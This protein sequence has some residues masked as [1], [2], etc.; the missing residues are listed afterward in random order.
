MKQLWGGVA[1]LSVA[2]FMVL[3][4]LRADVDPSAIATL[5]AL[6]I[7]AGLPAAG[8]AWLLAR[9]FGAGKRIDDRREA[10]RRETMEAEILNLA[11]RH[12]G[13][14]TAVEVAGALGVPTATAESL[15]KELMAQSLA[16][17][18]VTESGVLV[19]DFHDVKHLG[20]KHD[21]RGLL[22]P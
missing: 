1:L 9:H 8:G 3:G 22:E 20:E 10:L 15:L 21:A 6:L 13:K 12:E 18:E 5:V 11:G 7:G 4:F 19:Y 16:D 17:V 14:L 2:L